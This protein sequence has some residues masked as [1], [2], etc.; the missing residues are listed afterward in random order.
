MR[1][2]ERALVERTVLA[3]APSKLSRG[4][5]ENRV[6]TLETYQMFSIQPGPKKFEN[7]TTTGH[8]GFVFEQNLDWKI[9]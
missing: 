4:K 5:F 6:D 1:F 2:G 3:K 7:V 8:F 9:T